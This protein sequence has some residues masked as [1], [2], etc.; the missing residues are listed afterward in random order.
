MRE[1]FHVS[2]ACKPAARP[3]HFQPPD[4]NPTMAALLATPTMN[5]MPWLEHFGIAVSAISGVLAARGKKI[6]L[7]GV[8]VLALV[9]A[10]GGGTIRD[11]SLGATPVF[12]VGA[13]GYAITALAA[14][15]L[16]FF[17]ARWFT[18]PRRWFEAADA[19]ALA[20]FTI[21]GAS[22]SLRFDAGGLIAVALGT[23]TGVAGGI[24]R[25]VLLNEVPLVF[26]KDVT[27]YATA[28]IA[29]ATV[30]VVLRHI[31]DQPVWAVAAGV[32]LILV[33]RL[34]AIRWEWRLPEFRSGGD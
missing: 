19:I 33:L 27:L 13:Q 31:L 34:M 25:D 8:V 2:A 4:R 1:P 3:I 20:T 23:A 7:F 24:I 18:I 9:T 21:V 29:G 16:M 22:K 10:F 11:L 17:T 26:R 28:A 15:L 6:D 14:A 32:G 5:L 12:W 30:F